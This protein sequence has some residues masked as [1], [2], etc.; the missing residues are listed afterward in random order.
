MS[1]EKLYAAM[2]QYGMGD[3]VGGGDPA[4]V[5]A[6]N[7][8]SIIENLALRRDH[9]VFDFGCGIG[10]TAAPLAEFL[11]EGGRLVGSDIVPRHVQFCRQQFANFFDNTIF[12]CTEA[13]NPYYD[14]LAMETMQATATVEE[15]NFFFV[16]R[17]VFD[18]VVAFSVF[19]H[20]DPIMVADYFTSLR[21]VIKPAG[22]LFLT[23]FLDHPSNPA[24]SRLGPDEH[25]RDQDGNL[26]LAL[27]SPAK[28][29]ELATTAGLLIERISFG[30]W[31]GWP[32]STVRGQHYQDIVILR[33]NPDLPSPPIEFEPVRYLTLH[34]DVAE[35]GSDPEE[36]YLFHGHKEGRRLR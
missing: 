30:Y 2:R 25:F 10:R 31:R 32:P 4:A 36:H 19:T 18:L 12:Y 22:S 7:F 15:E 5:G 20:F 24:Q 6:Q 13:S 1:A 14:H 29:S 8:A 23:W 35:T 16:Y 3:W 11:N 28:V 21:D 27:Y 26:G 33:R 17:G 9:T 34:K